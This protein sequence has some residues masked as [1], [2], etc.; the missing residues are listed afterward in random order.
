MTI[1][2]VKGAM[3]H[4]IDELLHLKEII[5]KLNNM[6]PSDKDYYRMMLLLSV[7]H[8]TTR[9]H[10][11]ILGILETIKLEYYREFMSKNKSHSFLFP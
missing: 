7:L 10:E 4:Q 9:T 6:P 11:E 2:Q 3:E 8:N 5:K 1:N